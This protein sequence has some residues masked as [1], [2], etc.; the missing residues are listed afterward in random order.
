MILISE[1]I[2]EKK[3]RNRVLVTIF[4]QISTS[5]LHKRQWLVLKKRCTSSQLLLQFGYDTGKG[6]LG[7][8]FREE[9]RGPDGTVKGA[10]GYI[11]A[12]GEQ[13]RLK[14]KSLSMNTNILSHVPFPVKRIVKYTAGK[15]GFQIDSDNPAPKAQNH[16]A[17]A[18]PPR[19]QP[20]PQYQVKYSD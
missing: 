18:S 13:V 20:A 14:S 16:M 8:S 4:I 19:A 5:S 10:Y 3:T 17:A 15:A 11:D 6:P 1:L 2:F 12:N 7:Q 9:T